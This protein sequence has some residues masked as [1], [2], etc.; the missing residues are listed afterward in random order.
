MVL[1]SGSKLTLRWWKLSTIIAGTA[2]AAAYLLQILVAESLPT[3]LRWLLTS[4]GSI[5]LALSLI[6]P[7]WKANSNDR[8]LKTALELAN[9]AVA[10]YDRRM[11]EV[12]IPLSGMLAALMA[13]PTPRARE[14]QQG[15][16]KQAVVGYAL[17][18]ISGTSPRSCFY[19]FQ[20]GTPRRLTCT[21]LWKGRTRAPRLEFVDGDPAGS[22]A[23]RVLDTRTTK[24]VQEINEQN[25]PGM[26]AGRDYSTYIQA[27]VYNG[28]NSYGLLAVDAPS[29]GDFNDK[30]IR[31]VELLA[32]LLGCALAVK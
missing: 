30:D 31:L 8:K 19:A 26:L 17:D 23:F 24:Y 10:A 20:D 6:L 11:H 15:Q 27:P 13:A 7:I 4:I 1:G 2:G 25:S 32:Q 21:T 18:I 3:L 16:I 14:M 12:L 28:N 5:L 29:A 22:E 9:E